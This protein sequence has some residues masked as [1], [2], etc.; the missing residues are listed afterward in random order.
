MKM[1][2]LPLIRQ[3]DSFAELFGQDLLTRRLSPLQSSLLRHLFSRRNQTQ[4]LTPFFG[5]LE[6][7]LARPNSTKTS[8]RKRMRI[9]KLKLNSF[10]VSRLARTFARSTRMPVEIIGEVGTPGAAAE[11]LDAQGKLA[12][13]HIPQ[14]CADPPPEMRLEHV[15]H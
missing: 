7:A 2:T 10:A 3:P 6:V 12:N 9:R 14:M 1:A 4:N 15:W 13:R 8:K 5:R 11:W